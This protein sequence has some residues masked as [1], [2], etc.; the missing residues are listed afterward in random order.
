MIHV[1]WGQIIKVKLHALA[2]KE[3]FVHPCLVILKVKIIFGALVPDLR[4]FT[5]PQE[6]H[7]S[8]LVL[9]Y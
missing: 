1:T 7:H 9:K 5:V 2:V 4:W 8:V 3:D 6:L